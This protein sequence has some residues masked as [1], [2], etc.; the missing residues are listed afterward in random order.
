MKISEFEPNVIIARSR[1]G[2]YAASL[3]NLENMNQKCTFLL[4]SAMAT[5]KCVIANKPI[6]LYHAKDDGINNIN[7]VRKDCESYPLS[8]L[9]IRDCAFN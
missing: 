4:L 3:L 2:Y 1:G 9:I 6:L 8:K 5:Q 7:K